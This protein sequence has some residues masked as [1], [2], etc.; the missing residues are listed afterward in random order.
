MGVWKYEGKSITKTS[1]F[2]DGTFGFIYKIINNKT[3]KWYIG[4]K[5]LYFTR[6]QKIGKRELSKRKD[7]RGPKKRKV[8]KE[9]DWL[10]YYGSQENLLKDVQ[11]YGNNNFS[12]T[13]LCFCKSKKNLTYQE[14]RLQF[15]N[16]CLESDNCYVESIAGRYFRK[17][18]L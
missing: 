1:Q 15:I 16:G 13:I 4:K 2:P 17:D 14:T 3:G 9:S 6:T 11:Q 18:T 5:Q 7:R 12:R 8:V 10:T